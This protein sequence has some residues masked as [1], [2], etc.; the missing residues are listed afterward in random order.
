MANILEPTDEMRLEFA[1]W[2]ATL[3]D[4]VRVVAEKLPPWKLYR[5]TD[6]GHRVYILSYDEGTDGKAYLRVNVSGRY[7]SLDIEREVFGVDPESLEECELPAEGER[8][9]VR[10]ETQEE[11]EKYI[12]EV[13]PMVMAQ[14]NR[15]NN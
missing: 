8:V 5:M 11:I 13:R 2:T 9:G 1:K 4:F 6:T 14:R 15:D 3:P 7:N 12:D 10:L